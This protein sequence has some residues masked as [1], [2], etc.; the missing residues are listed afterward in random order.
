MDRMGHD[1]ERA[2]MSYLHGS[3]KRRQA[4]ADT[5]SQLASEELKRGSK[6]NAARPR[7]SRSGTEAPRGFLTVEGRPGETGTG[8]CC[9]NDLARARS[10]SALKVS[11]A[12]TAACRPPRLCL[13]QT[14]IRWE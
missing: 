3:A 14:P 6:R 2:A 8:S 5:L 4:I 10:A 7:G 13:A 9:P 1:S 11:R 12:S